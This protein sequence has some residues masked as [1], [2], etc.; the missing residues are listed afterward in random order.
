MTEDC[1]ERGVPI[2]WVLVPRVGRKSDALV[3]PAL[4]ETARAAGFTQIVDLSNA[5][6]GLDPARLAADHDDFHPNASGHARLAQRLDDAVKDSPERPGI[7]ETNTAG[8][9]SRLS[10]RAGRKG[11]VKDAQV[12]AAVFPN[13]PGGP[14][15]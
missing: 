14:P 7:W 6:D 10:T 15:R 8:I 11:G 9:R 2:Y 1:R 4:I 13:I 3:Q 12:K 5:F